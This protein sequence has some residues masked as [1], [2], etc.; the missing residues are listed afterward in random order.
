MPS[1]IESIEQVDRDLSS[2]FN[3]I[4]FVEKIEEKIKYINEIPELVNRI[5]ELRC[6]PIIAV[7]NEA[8]SSQFIASFPENGKRYSEQIFI[9][10]SRSTYDHMMSE[11]KLLIDNRS[12][13]RPPF[14]CSSKLR[15]KEIK[16]SV[17]QLDTE[18][19]PIYEKLFKKIGT[20]DE[21]DAIIEI[22]KIIENLEEKELILIKD[23][24]KKLSTVITDK[25][26]LNIENLSARIIAIWFLAESY[27][28]PPMLFYSLIT[29]HNVLNGYYSKEEIEKRRKRI[30]N[31]IRCNNKLH[32]ADG[33]NIHKLLIFLF[34]V[35]KYPRKVNI[36]QYEK[37]SD[38]DDFKK[39]HVKCLRVMYNNIC[40]IGK[41]PLSHIK[42]YK[43][44]LTAG[45]ENV[46]VN[47]V[48]HYLRICG[49]DEESAEATA[50][51]ILEALR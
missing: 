31:S 21:K 7:G 37:S 6:G 23:E 19:Q 11:L 33:D 46:F 18:F 9:K 27:C 40:A 29:L 51:R 1:D 45:R 4:S 14:I 5:R 2:K 17:R 43:S 39:K 32:L 25:E 42:Y 30:A 41:D 50:L 24:V 22:N 35:I 10:T 8:F 20:E 44:E 36:G 13:K 28:Y 47:C 38:V 26:S 34:Q 48:T 16:E 3:P 15:M 49:F 12:S